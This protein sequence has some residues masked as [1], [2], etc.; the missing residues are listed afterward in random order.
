MKLHTVIFL[1]LLT[2][3]CRS[4]GVIVANDGVP[5]IKD[6]WLVSAEAKGQF[7]AEELKKT[8]GPLAA[9]IKN[10]YSAYSITY[11]TTNE[12]NQP[13]VASGAVL[14]PDVKGPVPLLN[15]NH[16]TLFPAQEK[17]A[18]SYLGNSFELGIGKMLSATG[19]LV[20]LPDYTG[21][22]S[23]KNEK[24]PYGAY[25]VVARTVIDMLR[26]VKEFCDKNNIV[27]S[28]KNFFSGWSEGAAVTLATV[29]SLEQDHKGEF[30]PTA[31][32]LNA[33]PYY[34]S[35]FADYVVESERPLTY[36][37]SYIWILQA[38]NRVYHINKPL[39]YYFNE[40][41]ATAIAEGKDGD[42]PRDPQLLFTKTFLDNYK[43][44]RDTALKN[45][46][47][48]NDLWNWKPESKIVFC[49][50]DKDEY[51]PIF[52]SEK[53]YNTMKE[54]GADV[55]LNVFKGQTHASGVFNFMQ[56]LMSTLMSAN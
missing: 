51:V 40:P 7:T 49:H 50:G 32:V 47:L 28:G 48:D 55:T 45:A 10:G 21:Y 19:Y 34:T 43:A 31:T 27:L 44:G 42:I 36:I 6:K 23:T 24:H 13:V 11:N 17:N 35:R 37:R 30:T 29:Q 41:A 26:A 25:R 53:A 3:S 15:Y 12:D 56:V 4:A 22:G 46:I 16:G 14:V 20:V 5:N 52:N 38:Y 1:L 18:P 33:G 9:S 54:K 2:L 39:T 8:Y